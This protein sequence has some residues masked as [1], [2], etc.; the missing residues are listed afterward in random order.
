MFPSTW[1]HCPGF[2]EVLSQSP[3]LWVLCGANA[4]TWEEVS[5]RIYMHDIQTQYSLCFA[6]PWLLIGLFGKIL[7]CF[8]HT[9]VPFGASGLRARA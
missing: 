8:L 5:A 2:S 1:A 7:W 4:W 6:I 9:S 3:L